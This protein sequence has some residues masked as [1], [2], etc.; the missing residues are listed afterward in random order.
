MSGSKQP[1][2][3]SLNWLLGGLSKEEY[4]RILVNLERVTLSLGE[5]LYHPQEP[6]QYIYFPDNGCVV[7]MLAMMEDGSTVEVGVVGSEGMVGI[8]VF[9]G[10]QATPYCARVQM[11]GTALRIN[12]DVLKRVLS[13]V[14]S[15]H[16]ILLRY[17]HALMVQIAQNSACNRR[18][19]LEARLAR[20]LLVCHDRARN[21]DFP[22]THEFIS[23]MLGVRRPGI[24]IAAGEFQ[25][26]GLIRHYRGHITILNR[27][28]LERVS[29]ECYRVVREELQNYLTTIVPHPQL[30][31]AL[32]MKS[33]ETLASQY[34]N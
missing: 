1:T 7:S 14:H 18:H 29:C 33:F 16:G 34:E 22:I 27:A 20:W 2:N 19:S 10:V 17:T 13:D 5:V 21:D 31:A 24:S 25:K 6:T 9:W 11:P 30:Q 12:A 8:W 23:E 26:R 32:S 3:H 28:G 4:G 15:L